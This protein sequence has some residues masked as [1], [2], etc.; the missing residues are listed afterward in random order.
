[1]ELIE[2]IGPDACLFVDL[3]EYVLISS[4]V[5]LIESACL[6]LVV[7]FYCDC[8]FCALLGLDCSDVQ[9]V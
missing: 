1:M 9:R 3:G 4:C 5:N 2:W 6:A 8:F 7:I